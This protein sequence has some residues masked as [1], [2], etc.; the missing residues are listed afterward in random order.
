MRLAGAKNTSPL[1]PPHGLFLRNPPGLEIQLSAGA[2]F[3]GINHTRK[4]WMHQLQKSG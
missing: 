3:A 1:S 2:Q 4:R